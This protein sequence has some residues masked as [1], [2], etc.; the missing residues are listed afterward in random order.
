MEKPR[1]AGCPTGPRPSLV[2]ARTRGERRDLLA[3]SRRT[4]RDRALRLFSKAWKKPLPFLFQPIEIFLRNIP[5][6]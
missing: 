4:G 6:W 1:A 2:L 5:Q 3:F